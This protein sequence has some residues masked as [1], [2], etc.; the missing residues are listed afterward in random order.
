MLFG[1]AACTT[2]PAPT[3]APQPPAGGDATPEPPAHTGPAQI[4]RI[5]HVSAPHTARNLAVVALA[6]YVMEQL[7]GV[8]DIQVFPAGMLGT[9]LEMGQG[10]QTGALELTVQGAGAFGGF[11]PAVGAVEV[12]G[13]WPGERDQVR[14]LIAESYIPHI[15]E[16]MD[17]VGMR[18]MDYWFEE[19]V[20]IG[21]TVPIRTLEDF[22]GVRIRT[23]AS[24]TQLAIMEALGGTPLPMDPGEIY[25]GILTGV[26]DGTHNGFTMIFSNML[27]EVINYITA[28]NHALAGVYLVASLEWWNNLHPDHQAVFMSGLY[29]AREVFEAAILEELGAAQLAFATHD[30]EVIQL[31]AEE[32]ARWMEVLAPVAQIYFDQTPL[33]EDLVEF[34]RSESQRL[35]G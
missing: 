17:H 30:V 27:H 1:L 9:A 25:Q 29:V 6:D 7:P 5:G 31:S 13:V 4:V 24:P 20:T 21:S 2:T 28:S 12:P 15:R 32:R 11:E 8:F 3:P 19:F 33:G 23:M 14:Q 18:M 10:L 16:V 35:F 34:I 26:V 22:P